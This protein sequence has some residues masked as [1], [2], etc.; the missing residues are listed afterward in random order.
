MTQANIYRRRNGDYGAS[1]DGVADTGHHIVRSEK[2][3]FTVYSLN[4]PERAIATLVTQ[5]EAEKAI[6]EDWRTAE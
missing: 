2:G 1:C 3:Y 5:P 6:A 4:E